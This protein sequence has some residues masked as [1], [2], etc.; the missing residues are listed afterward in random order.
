[1]KKTAK[2]L[3]LSRETLRQLNPQTLEDAVGGTYP[4]P[5][6]RYQNTCL[7]ALCTSEPLTQNTQTNCA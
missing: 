1:M 7:R 2:K 3:I 4:D 5:P 6:T